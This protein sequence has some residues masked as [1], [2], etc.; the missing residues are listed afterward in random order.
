MGSYWQEAA[1]ILGLVLLN[2]FFAA[3]EIA[4]LSSRPIRI[5]QLAEQ[6]N[7]SAMALVRLTADRGRFLATIQV[8]I[9]LAGF[10]ASASAAV[11]IAADLTVGLT[12]L[13]VAPAAA[14]SLA[15]LFITLLVSYV[16]LVLGELVPKR[17]ALQAP[18]TMAL[19]TARPVLL[20][21]RLA[22]PFAL[23]LTW[24]TN[25]VVRLLGGQV[26]AR[27]QP[28]SEEEL[29]FYVEEHQDLEAEEKKMIAGVF[30]FGDRLVRHIMVPRP[31]MECIQEDTPL[32][33]ALAQMRQHGYWRYPVYREDYDEIVGIITVK[34]LLFRMSE[35]GP[36]TPVSAV[37]APAQFVPEAKRALELLKEM[38]AADDQ[39][40]IVVDEYGGV[41]GLVTL[42]DLLEEIVGDVGE[43]EVPEGE[44]ATP[45]EV[46]L[47]ATE[48]V[49]EAAER[50]R[51][52][53]PEGPHYE[54]LAGYILHVLGAIPKEGASLDVEGWRLVV[55]KMDGHRIDRVRA[56]SKATGQAPVL[57]RRGEPS[58]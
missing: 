15:V 20:L 50:L 27:E 18:E 6:G 33:A 3:A 13:G 55:E 58:P 30:D 34:R 41:A 5:R 24:S 44:A 28:L 31:Q 35:N 10:L 1:L 21:S 46:V 23:F 32:R 48:T 43:D 53:L 56:V 25:L 49:A 36:D 2:A 22:G 57:T 52:R 51:I 38:L 14:R 29:R 54:T 39:M 12:A 16:T 17:M 8:G 42:E 37:M 4:V 19:V 7:R 40:A 47:D 9:T 11:G 26:E 45:A